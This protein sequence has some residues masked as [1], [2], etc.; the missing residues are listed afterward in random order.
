MLPA[1]GI[2]VPAGL[3]E[4]RVLPVRDLQLVDQ[5]LTQAD[6]RGLLESRCEQPVRVA[7]RTRVHRHHLCRNGLLRTELDGR[8]PGEPPRTNR[9]FPRSVPLELEP[10]A[11]L[12]EREAL[13]LYGRGSKL[14]PRGFRWSVVPTGNQGPWRVG[15][16]SERDGH[17]GPETLA[18]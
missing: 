10:D 9:E 8:H 2:T 15:L 1:G 14:L 17:T 3:H 7:A 12:P 16:E 13:D 6:V 5:E 11:R 18:E 4:R